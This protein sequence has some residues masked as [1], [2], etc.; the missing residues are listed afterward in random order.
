VSAG[1]RVLVIAH[2]D[3]LRGELQRRLQEA[4][5]EVLA[6]RCGSH[7]LGVLDLMRP[8]VVVMDVALRGEGCPEGPR[9][10]AFHLLHAIR[11]RDAHVPVLVT[12]ERSTPDE[13]VR[14]LRLGADG[15]LG[16]PLSAPELAAHVE[17]LL[18]RAGGAGRT[19]GTQP[20]PAPPEAARAPA[21]AGLVRFGDVEVD[22][23][24]RAVRRNGRPVL[25][26][27]READLLFELAK[28]REQVVDRRALLRD[29]WH[30][31]EGA[32]SRTVDSHM[33]ELRRKLEP[34]PA[35]PRYLVTVHGRGYKLR[36]TRNG[37]A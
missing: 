14:A 28:R 17:A 20:P 6:E 5:Y 7:G 24:T 3:R 33:A 34:D 22:L 37:S 27:A 8:D 13:R 10:D 9:A 16:C 1:G 15:Y 19:R 2:S 32:R 36:D 31:A 18:R 23:D 11:A 35:R 29:V 21:P 12:S 25:L 4:G 26:R 30:Y